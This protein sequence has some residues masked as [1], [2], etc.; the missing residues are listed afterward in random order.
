LLVR[1]YAALVE[2]G[3]CEPMPAETVVRA[4][5][6][7]SPRV[8]ADL[9][10]TWSVP[11]LVVDAIRYHDAP[12]MAPAGHRRFT[13]MI[14]LAAAMGG[15]LADRAR[16]SQVAEKI[17]GHPSLEMLEMTEVRIAPVAMEI[18]SEARQLTSALGR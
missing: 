10:A 18:A 17:A 9:L 4:V 13:A 14:A 16:P 11:S 2:E 8:G 7:L 12:H 15:M 5:V 1:A 3:R 6:P